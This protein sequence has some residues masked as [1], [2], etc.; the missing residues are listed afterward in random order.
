MRI[1]D[2]PS[3]TRSLCAVDVV[4]AHRNSSID[5]TFLIQT[6]ETVQL[7]NGMSETVLAFPYE[8]EAQLA[9]VIVQE[10]DLSMIVGRDFRQHLL[11]RHVVEYDGFH[12]SR[13]VGLNGVGR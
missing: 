8:V 1:P 13:R 5:I 3:P 2:V 7:I 6:F 9:R 12:G 4:T 10:R 11:Q